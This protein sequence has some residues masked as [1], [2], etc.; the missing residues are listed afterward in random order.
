V[1]T[2][3]ADVVLVQP[4]SADIHRAEHLGLAYLASGLRQAAV[5]TQVVDAHL[6]GIPVRRVVDLVAEASPRVVGVTATQPDAPAMVAIARRVRQRLPAA[7][8]AVGGHFATFCHGGL[9]Q[10][11]PAI[12]SV[13]RGEG[14]IVFADLVQRVL[15]GE[16][17]RAL[18]GVSFRRN[19][20]VVSTAPGPLVTDLDRL[21]FPARDTAGIAM[22]RSGWLSM[23]SSRGCY[24]RCTFCSIR[25]FYGLQ[26]GRAW[27]ARSPENVVEEM[28]W[29]ARG[30]RCNRFTFRDDTFVGPGIRGK[31]RAHGIADQMIGRGL[32]VEFAVECRANDVERDLFLHLREAGLRVTYIGL[33]SGNQR[34]LDR[35]CKGT[36]VEDGRRALSILSDLGIEARVS[37]IMFDP[38]STLDECLD[39][40]RFVAAAG[41]LRNAAGFGNTVIPLDGTELREK[42]REQGRLRGSYLKGYS[43]SWRDPAVGRCARALASLARLLRAVPPPFVARR[44]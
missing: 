25:A 8:I 11:V 16:E 15:A 20:V 18:P 22:A 39:T 41:V 12:D 9:L 31:E 34:Q 4:P 28:T 32:K 7:H 27:R 43:Y 23:S 3:A 30:H 26:A 13:V 24:G 44:H 14:D 19:G 40:L 38:D 1:K 29:L 17:W 5:R 10:D 6:S 35:F 36:T 42:L 21:P 2:V 33:E 37:L